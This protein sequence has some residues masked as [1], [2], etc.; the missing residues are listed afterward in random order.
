MSR[1]N[2]Q[3]KLQVGS[4]VSHNGQRYEVFAI[5]RKHAYW[6]LPRT[7]LARETDVQVLHPGAAERVWVSAVDVKL[8]SFRE[9][10]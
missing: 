8:L 3:A 10:V 4:I 7:E 5:R 2:L 6:R 1:N 9:T